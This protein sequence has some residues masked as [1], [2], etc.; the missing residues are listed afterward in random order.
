MQKTFHGHNGWAQILACLGGKR[1]EARLEN[2]SYQPSL[3]GL[4]FLFL[5]TRQFLPGYFHSPL[6]GLDR[7]SRQNIAMLKSRRQR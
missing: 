4:S 5:L 1:R 3:P 2:A 7:G 6:P